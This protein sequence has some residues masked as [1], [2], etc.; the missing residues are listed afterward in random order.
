MC[1]W[2]NATRQIFAD[3]ALTQ[4]HQFIPAATISDVHG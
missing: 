3:S 4:V 2:H 1:V